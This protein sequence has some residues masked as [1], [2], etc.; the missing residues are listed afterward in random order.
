MFDQPLLEKKKPFLSPHSSYICNK[1]NRLCKQK[2][3]KRCS[4]KMTISLHIAM[5]LQKDVYMVSHPIMDINTQ[6]NRMTLS[7]VRSSL[8]MTK[9]VY[10]FDIKILFQKLTPFVGW[11]RVSSHV[12]IFR[13]TQQM[14]KSNQPTVAFLYI[15]I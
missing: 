9:L 1:R 5:K 6:Y 7:L 3:Y 12:L 2:N 4:E 8:L 15:S 14:W 10:F 13:D 11:A